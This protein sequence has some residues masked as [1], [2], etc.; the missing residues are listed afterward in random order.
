[1]KCR[2]GAKIA[3][4]A[5]SDDEPEFRSLPP[6][7]AT[8]SRKPRGKSGPAFRLNL[9]PKFFKNLL[10]LAIAA[11]VCVGVFYVIKFGTDVATMAISTKKVAGLKKDTMAV[12]N[13]SSDRIRKNREAVE[14]ML[15]NQNALP[16]S[17]AVRPLLDQIAADTNVVVAGLGSVT[18]PDGVIDGQDF[19]GGWRD[20]IAGASALLT[21]GIPPLVELRNDSS[22][23]WSE[24]VIEVEIKLQ[25]I[26]IK[27]C[28]ML[29]AMMAR[30]VEFY[31]KNKV[32][33]SRGEP[34]LRQQIEMMLGG[35]RSEQ[36]R[37]TRK[38]ANPAGDPIS[39]PWFPPVDVASAAPMRNE[40]PPEAAVPQGPPPIGRPGSG[41]TNAAPPRKRERKKR[42]FR[43]E[44]PVATVEIE[45]LDK[46]KRGMKVW[47]HQGT[48]EQAEV[49]GRNPGDWLVARLKTGF[50][51]GQVT[52][53][54][55]DNFRIEE[56]EFDRA[57]LKD[58][59]TLSNEPPLTAKQMIDLNSGANRTN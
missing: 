40:P 1:V 14:A 9:S 49:A 36:Q 53:Q 26:R 10:K 8:A 25:E 13:A 33:M 37:L 47:I 38:L 32:G 20:S 56:S 4:P 48:W 44:T 58:V 3:V 18:I 55:L 24:R 41:P 21:N 12:V 46:V 35:A 19:V 34:E 51:K 7:R 54:P 45:S 31:K 57:D 52:T 22:R 39:E 16:S 23:E 30:H 29:L 6:R 42:S 27:D 17:D 59:A 11:V 2:C 15:R 50:I 28:E 5:E 43:S